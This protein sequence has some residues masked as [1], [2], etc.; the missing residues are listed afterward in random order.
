MRTFNELIN[1]FGTSTSEKGSGRWHAALINKEE[2]YKVLFTSQGSFMGI[3]T[4]SQPL[5]DLTNIAPLD[6]FNMSFIEISQEEY[7]V[8]REYSL[9]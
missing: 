8:L 2:F 7:E 3:S 5:T 6:K 9:F 1:C 4:E